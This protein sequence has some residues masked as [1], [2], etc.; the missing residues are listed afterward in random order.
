M[1]TTMDGLAAGRGEAGPRGGA[2]L[3]CAVLG[4]EMDNRI[5][6]GDHATPRCARCDGRILHEDG[7]ITHTRHVLGCFLRH[8]TYV[9]TGERDAHNEY[10]CV[11]CGHPLLFGR[12]AD[13]Y[14][15]AGLFHKKV[16]YLCGLLGHHVHAVGERHGLTE[17]ACRCGHPFLLAA[18]G[19][20]RVTHPLRCTSSGHRV[21][22]VEQRESYREHRCVD[23][24]HTFGVAA[25][26]H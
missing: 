7:R 14:S 15:D 3:L 22:F 25:T 23:C 17:Y 18:R 19:L 26:G 20:S 1:S 12:E 10:T 16:K 21:V 6:A 13:P 4:H 8:H 24:G 9:R 5:L 11:R 2:A